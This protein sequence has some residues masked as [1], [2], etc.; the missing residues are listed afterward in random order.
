MT[1]SDTT[2]STPPA[3]ATAA[4]RLVA[5]DWGS[6]QLR[7]YRL[8]DGGTELEQR[9]S[10]Q[11]ASRLHGGAAAFDTALHALAGD[12][13]QPGT[14]VLA[15]G[16]VGSAHGWREAPYVD[17]PVQLNQLHRHLAAVTTGRGLSVHIVPGVCGRDDQQLPDVMRGEE[18]QLLGW[19]ASSAAAAAGNAT[20]VMPGT[21]SKWVRLANG[22]LQSF[23][24]RMTGELY[25]LLRQHSVLAR[26]MVEGAPFQPEAFVR[27]VRLAGQGR[28]GDLGH[29]LFSVRTLG[30][31]GD[32]APEGLAD[33]L[34]GLLI[35]DEL[36]AGLADGAADDQAD[37]PTG[38][39]NQAPVTLIGEAALC[40][41]YRLALQAF[42]RQAQVQTA[43]LAAQGL[44]QVGR[45]SGLC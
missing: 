24:T 22:R 6:S 1:P 3:A 29:R 31:F 7:A 42:G 14:S 12:W 28:P 43:S 26:L 40:E 19:L 44:W 2:T 18:T 35:G 8:G 4:T 27:G 25:A 23:A 41:R 15:C 33:Y 45:Q 30:L 11:G 38:S 10:D 17:C 39:H 32:I 37:G 13:L 21:H 9:S 36:A 34:S 5:L 16:M 20:V